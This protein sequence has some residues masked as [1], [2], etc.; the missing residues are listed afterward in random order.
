MPNFFDFLKSE[1][2][3]SAS[4]FHKLFGYQLIDLL[5][6]YKGTLWDRLQIFRAAPGGGKTSIMRLFSNESLSLI[7][8][9]RELPE[10]GPL[11]N[12]VKALGALNK[13][14]PAIMGIRLSCRFNYAQIEDM[15]IEVALKDRIFWTLINTRALLGILQTMNYH[16]GMNVPQ[17]LD[18]VDFSI[19]QEFQ[20]AFKTL[21]GE[22]NGQI[23]YNNA[24]KLETMMCTAINRI[25]QPDLSGMPTVGNALIWSALDRNSLLINGR[26]LEKKILIMLDDL[27]YLAPR[28]RNLLITELQE[29]YPTARWVA[30]RYQ[31]I[32]S[33]EVI[34][35]GSNERRD[36]VIHRLEDW[37]VNSK[38]KFY[39]LLE[40]T[41]NKRLQSSSIIDVFEFESLVP[42][43]ALSESHISKSCVSEMKR[44]LE[45][46][47]QKENRFKSWVSSLEKLD[48][49]NYETAVKWRALEILMIRKQKRDYTLFP[50]EELPYE[51]MDKMDS[52]G[53]Q[54]A[55]RLFLSKEFGLPYYSGYHCLKVLSSGNVEQFL[56][57]CGGEFSEVMATATLRRSKHPTIANE[58]Q[59]AIIKEIAQK[60][61]DQIPRKMQSGNKIKN[62]VFNAA[63]MAQKR[64][65][66]PSA[67]YAPGV[68]G[69]G[70]SALDVQRLSDRSFLK[71]N[72]KYK[73]VSE[74][75]KNA[76]AN[77]VFEVRP[78]QHCKGQEWMV[79]Y[80]NRLFCA[81]FW[82][83]I[84]YG[85]WKE[86]KF[87][88]IYSWVIA[89]PDKKL[90]QKGLFE[91]V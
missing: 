62:L 34:Q 7:Y 86:Q 16:S 17:N 38:N 23:V 83:P 3:E 5:E 57:L 53:V 41:A 69:F 47:T 85:G 8:A 75:L 60:R 44:R 90:L 56:Q 52:S 35:V 65:Y 51:E 80:L 12:V 74:V 37:A 22:G 28:Q 91:D 31:A 66:E 67:P 36:Y 4:S 11:L 1:Q 10:Y 48:E 55:A 40:Y 50:N 64:T 2:L 29:V 79:L 61:I 9:N 26:S 73:L 32:D 20:G 77:N 81:Y 89:A 33:D 30:E 43:M 24:S 82:L 58:R 87:D 78:K 70:I 19:S 71:E 84:E 25:N 59:Q 6:D 15:K 46:I 76:I 72:P 27:Q 21:F 13:N 49:N 63:Y 88:T 42:D 18:E 39:K 54:N 45:R 14:G 68:S